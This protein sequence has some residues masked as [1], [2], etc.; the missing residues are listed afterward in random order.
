MCACTKFC[1]A[2]SISLWYFVVMFCFLLFGFSLL[3]R[4]WDCFAV[5]IL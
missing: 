1:L 2:E 3:F 4:G 5:A